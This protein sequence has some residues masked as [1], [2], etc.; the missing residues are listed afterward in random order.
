MSKLLS[1]KVALPCCGRLT[2]SAVSSRAMSVQPATKLFINGEFV[3]S[4]TSEWIDVRNPATQEIVTRV[5]KST[6]HELNEAAHSAQL[7]FGEWKRTSVL[8]RQR[9]M[10]DLQHAIRNNMD[11]LAES[12]VH[13]QGKV[14]GDARGDVLRGLQVV[15]NMAGIT[16]YL[17][18][19]KLEVSADM[20]TYTVREPL[21]VVAG[22]CPFNFPAMIPLW[23]FPVALA[24]GNTC[25]L[26]PSERDPGAAMIL[27]ELCDQVGIPKGV[28]NI[29]HG[30]HDTVDFLTA[31]KR[32]R[33]V[34]FVGGDKAGKYIYERATQHGKRCQANLGAKNHAVVLPDADREHA[35]NAIIGAA[36]GA[37]GQRCMALSVAVFVGDSADW[38]PEI[39]ERA[40]K[41]QV[42]GGMEEGADLGPMI[43]PEA[44]HRAESLIQSAVD[45]GASLVL[46]GR[47]HKV[48]KYP[49]GNFLG[50]TVI[51][52]AQKSMDC[53][54]QE[55]FGPVLTCVRAESMDDALE[56]VNSNRYGN[57][58]SVFTRSGASARRFQSDVEAGQVGINVPIPVPLP[59]FSF[60]GNKGSFLG[61]TNFYGRAGVS[62]YTQLKTITSHWRKQDAQAVE[63]KASVHMPT[64]S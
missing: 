50:P 10:L 23:M 53:Y 29:V 55:I 48:A 17:L 59:M 3:E 22:I 14:M 49:R 38:I 36:F 5:P 47:G 9:K 1:A 12:I 62:F 31:D 61:D 2:R 21:G 34:S 63:A 41:L 57:G 43:S 19:H 39:V 13:E 6:P 60:T 42:N 54:Q 35:I 46:D 32:V 58:A 45:Q 7:A 51:D 26:K 4:Q 16:E 18:G 15:E 37:A 8:T 64:H 11:R 56:L 27:A 30:A 33:A 20:D 44:L 24:T 52:H 28:L 25:L 40:K